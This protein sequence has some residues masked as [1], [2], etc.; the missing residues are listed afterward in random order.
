MKK[1]A[2]SWARHY[3]TLLV[4][5]LT[6]LPQSLIAYDNVVKSHDD[7][8]AAKA[9]GP[10]SILW[11]YTMVDSIKKTVIL[12]C[13]SKLKGEV[14]NSAYRNP[15][16]S[17]LYF[18]EHR[19]KTWMQGWTKS[20]TLQIPDTL[21]GGLKVIGIHKWFLAK[22]IYYN[23]IDGVDCYKIL[24]LKSIIFP[25]NVVFI[26]S[27]ALKDDVNRDMP[28]DYGLYLKGKKTISNF[29]YS[30]TGNHIELGRNLKYLGTLEF[31]EF[32]SEGSIISRNPEPPLQHPKGSFSKAVM[33]NYVLYVP[34]KSVDL[35]K[36]AHGWKG[37]RTIKPI[38]DDISAI[39]LQPNE[40]K[41]GEDP[42]M[43]YT[44]EGQ[45]LGSGASFAEA[46]QIAAFKRYKGVVI[47]AQGSKRRKVIVK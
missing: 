1:T 25:D 39:S 32:Y 13:V 35:Y 31:Y 34:A 30:F 15:E 40:E 11:E 36:N 3:F 44:I 18:E 23:H 38:E 28:E 43:F 4:I 47:M 8:K 2:Y 12:T 21:E 42:V 9:Y 7:R 17:S 16:D 26:N 20:D 24:V 19:P 27:E 22:H 45:F 14:F 46:E 10:D 5:S 41:D 29:I 37:F 33:Q 6:I